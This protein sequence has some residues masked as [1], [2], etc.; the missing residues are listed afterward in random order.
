MFAVEGNGT[1]EWWL[2]FQHTP[3]DTINKP[4]LNRIVKVKDGC[5]YP[6]YR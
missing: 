4:T 1:D 3:L 5:T 6:D 2:V